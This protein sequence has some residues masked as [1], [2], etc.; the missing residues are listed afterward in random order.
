MRSSI[1]THNKLESIKN[2]N[3]D[4]ITRSINQHF[5]Q[6]KIDTWFKFYRNAGILRKYESKK[7]EH[8]LKGD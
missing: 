7:S 4:S 2:W 5:S 8:T 3:L 1:N 6:T